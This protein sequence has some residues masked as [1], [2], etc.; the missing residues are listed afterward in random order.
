ML[1]QVALYLELTLS[2]VVVLD[3]LKPLSTTWGLVDF[4]K[5]KCFT[6]LD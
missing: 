2:A 6:G 4:L 1:C 3:K 5:K